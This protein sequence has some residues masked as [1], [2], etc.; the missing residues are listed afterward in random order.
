VPD[1]ETDQLL[2]LYR[3]LT[4]RQ[5][6]VFEQITAGKTNQMV[7]D[8]L[9]ISVRTAEFHRAGIMKKFQAQNL[10][11]LTLARV[12]LE[13]YIADETSPDHGA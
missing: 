10:A 8:E 5:Q 7:A 2:T 1:T 4:P 6:Q 9:G 11:D 3:T 12:H 13:H